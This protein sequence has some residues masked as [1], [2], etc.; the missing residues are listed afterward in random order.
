[1]DVITVIPSV[2]GTIAFRHDDFGSRTTAVV[3]V[4]ITGAAE[5]FP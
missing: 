1:M 2:T 3:L 5:T 4:S